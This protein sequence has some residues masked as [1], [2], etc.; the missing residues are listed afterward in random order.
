MKY[1][2]QRLGAASHYRSLTGRSSSHESRNS[3][4]RDQPTRYAKYG[5]VLNMGRKRA[6]VVSG[7]MVLRRGRSSWLYGMPCWK[8]GK[9]ACSAVECGA[10]EMPLETIRGGNAKGKY[11]SA[12]CLQNQASLILERR[13]F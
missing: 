11:G 13:Q 2:M 12:I 1:I 10:K 3:A 7:Q 5:E 6:V 8:M 4:L 9:S